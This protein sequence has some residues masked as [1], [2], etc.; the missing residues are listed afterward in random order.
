[1]KNLTSEAGTIDSHDDG[2]V[3]RRRVTVQPSPPVVTVN[4]QGVTIEGP[5][6]DDLPGRRAGSED[7]QQ[8]CKVIMKRLVER[9][10]S[11]RMPLHFSGIDTVVGRSIRLSSKGSDG[12]VAGRRGGVAKLD[13]R[14][15]RTTLHSTSGP[16]LVGRG[17][18]TDGSSTIG[19]QKAKRMYPLARLGLN[20]GLIHI[21][22]APIHQPY[23]PRLANRWAY[24]KL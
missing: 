15:T 1:M 23:P 8:M 16:S 11:N 6:F 4:V 17:A 3:D 5:E 2:T 12:C 7:Q 13:Q 21:Q 14:V 24:V 9:Y 19:R 20:R 22:K 18:L 10:P